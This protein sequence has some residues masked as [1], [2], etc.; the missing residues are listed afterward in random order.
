MH[1]YIHTYTHMPHTYIRTYSSVLEALDVIQ[2]DNDDGRPSV[3][4]A[5]DRVRGSHTVNNRCLNA[6]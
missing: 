2:V 4:D 6:T 5:V 3:D 1:T